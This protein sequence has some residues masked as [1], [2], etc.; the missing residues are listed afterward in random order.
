[1]FDYDNAE[2]Q[3]FDGVLRFSK[4][5]SLID[6][7][8][9]SIVN[10]ISKLV[11]SRTVRAKFNLNA[12]YNINIINPI[13]RTVSGS[14]SSTGF[15]IP[16]SARVYYLDEDGNGYVRLYYLDASQNKIILNPKIGTINYDAGIINIKNLNITSLNDSLFEL[17]IVPASYDVVSALNQIVQ[18]SRTDLT[19]NMIADRTANGD[20]QAGYNYTFSSIT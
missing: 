12:E 8:D 19:V 18:I 14:L 3:K 20:L 1:M 15:L 6:A 11:I 7:A 9:P 16:G 13:A 10:N 4:L 2:L 17:R 5:L